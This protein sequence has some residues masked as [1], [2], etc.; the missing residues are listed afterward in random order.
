MVLGS[1]EIQKLKSFYEEV[2]RH[3]KALLAIDVKAA[4]NQ[5]TT[6]PKLMNKIPVQVR[7][8]LTQEKEENKDLTMD[9]LVNGLR[10]TVKILE[11]YG[12]QTR[13]QQQEVR[14]PH[15]RRPR[16]TSEASWTKNT[17]HGDTLI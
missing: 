10:R 12:V 5:A 13:E 9:G 1:Y 7:I 14:R 16:T 2:G 11:N 3:Y 4:D 17:P 8:K 15:N 6:V